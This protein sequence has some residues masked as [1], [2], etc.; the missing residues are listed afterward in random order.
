M[1]ESLLETARLIL[2]PFGQ[3]D[4]IRAWC[5]MDMDPEVM[6]H[7]RPP[8][9][10]LASAKDRLA[11]SMAD[12]DKIVGNWGVRR[13][14]DQM[15]IGRALLRWLPD[16]ERIEIGYRLAKTAWGKGFATELAQ[17]IIDHGFTTLGLDEIVGVYQPVNLGSRAVLAKC[18][19]TDFGMTQ[20]HGDTPKPMMGVTR[21]NWSAAN[22]KGTTPNVTRTS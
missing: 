6:R 19:M 4:H 10:D 16:N 3:D 18:G 21:Q 11:A 22:R 1:P 14:S 12:R 7:I 2:E 20:S 13:K 5:D 15:V 9:P 17:A 8:S